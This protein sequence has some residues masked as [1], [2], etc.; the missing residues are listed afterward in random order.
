MPR[1]ARELAQDLDD[2][3]RRHPEPRNDLERRCVKALELS[4]A[5]TKKAESRADRADSPRVG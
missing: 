5:V 3:K 4:L 2:Y 1:S